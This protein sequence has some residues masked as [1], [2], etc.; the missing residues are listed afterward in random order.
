MN[1]FSAKNIVHVVEQLTEEQE[2]DLEGN[3]SKFASS[4]TETEIADSIICKPSTSN[5]PLSQTSFGQASQ[6]SGITTSLQA[7]PPPLPFSAE[8]LVTPAQNHAAVTAVHLNSS[9][10]SSTPE[11]QTP[12][13]P[14]SVDS[15]SS[16]TPRGKSPI[17]Q[18][19]S[20]GTGEFRSPSKIPYSLSSFSTGLKNRNE[21][22]KLTCPTPGCDGSGHQTGLYTHHRSLSGCPR[23][24]DKSTIQCESFY[25][26]DFAML[27]FLF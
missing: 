23:R 8:S 18:F 10:R 22:G 24:P 5:L 26:C 27:F 25:S 16:H 12:Q 6:S 11:S 15:Q 17:V 1:K 9:E 4:I 14:L 20:F 21:A 13:S 7:N 19:S 2:E 3:T